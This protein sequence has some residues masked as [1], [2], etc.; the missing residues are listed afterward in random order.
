MPDMADVLSVHDG[1]QRLPIQTGVRGRYRRRIH[2]RAESACRSRRK[3]RNMAAT[4][5]RIVG[6]SADTPSLASTAWALATT[7]PL[8]VA[9]SDRP[10]AS[11]AVTTSPPLW[12]TTR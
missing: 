7:P 5:Y 12:A 2:S 11:P 6:R 8:G 9:I 3:Y 4:P 10:H 1:H